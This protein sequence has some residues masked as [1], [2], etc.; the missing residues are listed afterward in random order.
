MSTGQTQ[1]RKHGNPR[2]TAQHRRPRR[3]ARLLRWI[4]FWAIAGLL[5]VAGV[6]LPGVDRSNASYGAPT[7]NQS[8]SF[9]IQTLANML[10]GAN[11]WLDST[12][13][14]TLF[15]DTGCTT[16][17]SGSGTEV[18]C[19]KDRNDGAY[20]VSSYSATSFGTISA[21][22]IGGNQVLNIGTATDLRG[23]DRLGGQLSDVTV[24]VVAESLAPTNNF[25]V[26]LNGNRTAQAERFSVHLPYSNGNTYFDAGPC[27][28][29]NRSVTSGV[30][31][32]TPLL[33]V[34]WKDSVAGHS[35]HQVSGHP[36]AESTGSTVA[37]TSNGLRIGYLANHLFGELIVFDRN[38][39]PFEREAVAAY[40]RAK[41]GIA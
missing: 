6:A 35:Y 19:W 17:T 40:L 32:N 34:G 13:D 22:T 24:F 29:T 1:Q 33:F 25:L 36:I 2:Q 10:A 38:L 39:T 30:A 14:S 31:Q 8:N 7:S 16:P 21:S 20:N 23:P 4:G 12:D 15:S 5:A 28:T 3:S 18:K 11:W 9:E 26:N 41:W 27:C 37:T